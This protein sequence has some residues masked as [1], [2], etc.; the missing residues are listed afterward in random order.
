MIPDC[1]FELDDELLPDP[2]SFSRAQRKR[3][4]S[5]FDRACKLSDNY[6]REIEPVVRSGE[7]VTEIVDYA[8][9][10]AIDH[11]IIGYHEPTELIPIFRSVSE[12]V[13]RNA[14]MPVTVV[15]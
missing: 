13:T 7:A 4:E 9:S 8:E 15:C 11:I 5:V 10:H 2:N 14:S 6:G 3:A 12:S 1:D